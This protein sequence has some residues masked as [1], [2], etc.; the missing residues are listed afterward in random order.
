VRLPAA[1]LL[2][3]LLP[4]SFVEKDDTWQGATSLGSY[5][6]AKLANYDADWWK[7]KRSHLADLTVHLEGGTGCLCACPQGDPYLAAFEVYDVHGTQLMATVVLWP[8]VTVLPLQGLPLGQ[9]VYLR[10]SGV[11][12]GQSGASPY[13]LQLF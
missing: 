11:P 9:P 6:C 8:S 2:L 3:A 10:V 1:A 7:L 13:R 4:A 12:V 5:G